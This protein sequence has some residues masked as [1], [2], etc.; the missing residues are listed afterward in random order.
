MMDGR[1]NEADKQVSCQRT[2]HSHLQQLFLALSHRGKKPTWIIDLKDILKRAE[3]LERGGNESPSEA[4]PID[5]K[6]KASCVLVTPEL[7]RQRQENPWGSRAQA[8]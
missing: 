2:E 7:K 1:K 5:L 8:S 4:D 3:G 6:L